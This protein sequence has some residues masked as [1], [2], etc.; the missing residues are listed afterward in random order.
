MFLLGSLLFRIGSL[1]FAFIVRAVAL[2][3]TSL[4]REAWTINYMKALQ[5]DSYIFSG[6]DQTN[7]ARRVVCFENGFGLGASGA[8]FRDR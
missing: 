8:V 7:Q 4:A 5:G 3:K 6:V 1:F 2:E